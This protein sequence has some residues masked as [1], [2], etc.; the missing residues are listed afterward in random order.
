MYEVSWKT[1]RKGY[2]LF[3]QD[4]VKKELETDKRIHFLVE[5]DLKKH[6][7]IYDK[8]KDNWTCDCQFYSLKFKDCSHIIACRLFLERGEE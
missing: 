2:W 6:S 3:R 8:I 4:K 5:V 7:V 1:R